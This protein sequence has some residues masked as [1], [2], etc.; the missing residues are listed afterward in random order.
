MKNSWLSREILFFSLFF[1]AT[2]SHFFVF[3]DVIITY[4][5]LFSGI[6]LLISIDKVY[7]IVIQP[8]PFELHSAH[9][10]FTGFLLA[11][12][13]FDNYFAF[14]LLASLKTSLYTYRK[15]HFWKKGLNYRLFISGWRLDMLLSF[16]LIFC[17]FDFSNLSW[18]VIVRVLIGEII[19]RAEYYEELDVI[20]PQKQIEHDFNRLKK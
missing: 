16:P 7:R 4:T 14:I 9:V 11:S 6:L 5:A 19:D 1:I 2:T 12:V 13:L 18:W 17:F 15:Y 3:K 20:T 8:A 10:V